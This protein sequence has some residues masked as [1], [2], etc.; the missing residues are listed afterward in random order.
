M[1]PANS[2]SNVSL[3]VWEGAVA[4]RSFSS[5][6]EVLFNFSTTALFEVVTNAVIKVSGECVESFDS[7]PATVSIPITPD[8]AT[9]TI[10]VTM[11]L[12]EDRVTRLFVR[13]TDAQGMVLSGKTLY[14][15]I[16]GGNLMFISYDEFYTIVQEELSLREYANKRELALDLLESLKIMVA[17]SPYMRIRR[18]MINSRWQTIWGGKCMGPMTMF[19]MK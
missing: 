16:A 12:L 7:Y 5:S 15:Q 1:L 10:T 19:S 17:K 8:K 2:T 11:N 18:A 3:D 9:G 6:D 4:G 14:C 13:I